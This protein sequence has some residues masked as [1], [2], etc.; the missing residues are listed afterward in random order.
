MIA[1]VLV[2][3]LA[4]LDGG[5]DPGEQPAPEA[6]AP[7]AGAAVAAEP[8]VEALD[9][10]VLPAA[11]GA[12]IAEP[13]P[14]P[15][16]ST[17]TRDVVPKFIKGELSTYLGADRLVVQN[18]RIGVSAGLDRFG[19]VYYLLV[20][21]LVDLRFL[22]GAL[23]VGFGA[24]L[25]FEMVSLETNPATGNPF[26]TQNLGRI[27]KEDW[28]SFHDFGRLLKY[29]TYGKKEEPLYVSVGQRYATSIGHGA[30]T[31]RYSPNIDID[32][33]RV[34]AEVDA[35][36]RFG[37]F[38]L[39][40]NDVL[41]WNQ[42]SGIAFLK[43]F[44]FFNPQS[45]LLKSF[46][47]GLSGGL[48]WAAPY[49]LVV[50]NGVRVLDDQKRLVTENKPVGIVGADVEF[51]V[52][53]TEQV[54]LKPYV[55]FSMLVG[56]DFGLTGGLLGR[57]NVGKETVNAFRV[58]VE[59]RYLGSRYAPSHFDTFYEVDRF[60]YK[61]LP[62]V[63]PAVANYVPKGRYMLEHGLGERFGYYLEGSWG[64]PG[65]V[66]LTLALQGVSNSR[67]TDFVAHLEVPVLSFFQIFGSYYLRGV[68]SWSEL[69]YQ[70]DQGVLGL[71]GNKA[72][73][74][75][76]ARLKILPFL[77][78]N[79]RMYKTFRMNEALRRY[80]NQFGFVVDL[81]IGYEFRKKK[82]LP[83]PPPPN[84]FEGS[85]HSSFASR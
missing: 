44:S 66:G 76:G 49:N 33:P 35:Y 57:F 81:E 80:D 79:G 48:D 4:A 23:G 68:E 34:S 45:E 26:L 58:V 47:I 42:L 8:A 69:G 83:P 82:E 39:M 59:A 60:I 17:E 75:A 43:P 29:V 41:A 52:M 64:I 15:P 3:S 25:R 56:G 61:E 16:V 32:Y 5:A 63:D 12:P 51:K 27:R 13:A 55:D 30:I 36:N 65:A 77:F 72:V 14:A 78:L 46:S 1:A 62:R 67:A 40:V 28:D 19:D 21:P 18:T 31:R 84:A 71:F 10:G 74:F 38:E 7:E 37:G 53:K 85:A 70:P 50:E 20:E 54:D 2:V 6:P 9:A 24:P 22:D 11:L 73:A